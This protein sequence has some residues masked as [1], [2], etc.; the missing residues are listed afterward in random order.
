MSLEQITEWKCSSNAPSLDPRLV[1]LL[2]AICVWKKMQPLNP[3][4]LTTVI[5]SVRNPRYEAADRATVLYKTAVGRTRDTAAPINSDSKLRKQKSCR[6]KYLLRAHH[7]RSWR[8]SL[9]GDIHFRQM[10]P[11]MPEARIAGRVLTSS[12]W[13]RSDLAKRSRCACTQR[14]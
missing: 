10:N 14:A 8:G 9:P 3:I 5:A 6:P 4:S 1:P 12:F 2:G 11:S 7:L 13:P